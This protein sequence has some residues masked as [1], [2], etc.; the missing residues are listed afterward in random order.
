[1]GKD[2]CVN[3]LYYTKENDKCGFI[4]R[5]YPPL[6]LPLSEGNFTFVYPRIEFNWWCGEYKPII[7]YKFRNTF[8]YDALEIMDN[9]STR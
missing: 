4:C 2:T 9:E 8:P 6:A 1:M 3:C 5:R 7:S